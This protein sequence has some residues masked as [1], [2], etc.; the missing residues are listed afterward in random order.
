[1][2]DFDTIENCDWEAVP[3]C[4]CYECG[5][6][7]EE[8]E[9][10]ISEGGRICD[11]CAYEFR[12]MEKPSAYYFDDNNE[13]FDKK[14]Q[15]HFVNIMPDDAIIIDDDM[16]FCNTY[17]KAKERLLSVITKV[18]S[19]TQELKGSFIVSQN[20]GEFWYVLNEIINEPS[21]FKLYIYAP[22]DVVAKKYIRR[23][24]E[25]CV[26]RMGYLENPEDY[27]EEEFE[28]DDNY[29]TEEDVAKY[30][31]DLKKEEEQE[32]E[33][34]DEYDSYYT[35][36]ALCVTCGEINYAE[37]VC[38]VE[39]RSRIVCCDCIEIV[40]N[41]LECNNLTLDKLYDDLCFECKFKKPLREQMSLAVHLVIRSDIQRL[42][43]AHLNILTDYAE[44]C[45]FTIFDAYRYKS[46]CHYYDCCQM[47]H[48]HMWDAEEA[49]QF[50]CK[51]HSEYAEEMGC[52]FQN[53]Y[54]GTDYDGDYEEAICKV[55][56]SNHETN[57][58]PRIALRESS[59][60]VNP[61]VSAICMFKEICMS[62]VLEESLVDLCQYFG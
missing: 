62:N 49:M 58:I 59:Q 15:E 1:V 25:E 55:C 27:P 56:N 2:Y 4:E 46:R 43:S 41:C 22:K 31:E 12:V 47:I 57:M 13:K 34:Q 35:K 42:S 6:E 18:N 7:M 51:R 30:Y 33:E 8:K 52:H 37:P 60:G 61:I 21:M 3:I 14:A 16:L 11:D 28:E 48:P 17:D 23:Q 32:Q 50:C 53:V 20:N 19:I 44:L 29:A 5:K 9:G 10:Y 39:G 26:Y 54:D 38:E 45:E 40:N 36:K 24:L